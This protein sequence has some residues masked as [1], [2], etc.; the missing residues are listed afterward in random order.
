[1]HKLKTFAALVALLAAAG[2]R[3]SPDEPLVYRNA[4]DFTEPNGPGGGEPLEGPD[5]Y[6][7]GEARLALGIFYEGEFSEQVIKPQGLQ[8]AARMGRNAA[9]DHVE[10]AAVLAFIGAIERVQQLGQL[11]VADLILDF[12][13]FALDGAP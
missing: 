6:Q 12:A 3:P 11:P 13:E 5:P 9:R 8:N 2:C 10:A 4:A 7:P 1:M